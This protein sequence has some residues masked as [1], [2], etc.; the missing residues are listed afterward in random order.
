MV[1]VLLNWLAKLHPEKGQPIDGQKNKLATGRGLLP[2]AAYQVVTKS[3]F[4]SVG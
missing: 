2:M 1:S 3:P 4:S